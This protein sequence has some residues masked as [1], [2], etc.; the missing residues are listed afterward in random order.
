MQ[1]DSNVGHAQ[2]MQAAIEQAKRA[3]RGGDL[4]FGAVVVDARGA[5]VASAEDRIERDRDFTSHAE[6]LAVRAAAAAAGP[7]LSGCT[8]YSNGEPCALCF[9]AAWWT[10]MST[11]V[12][13]V[14]MTEL[15]AVRG[16]SMEEVMGPAHTMNQLLERKIE[17]VSDVLHDECLA[18]WTDAP[19]G[20]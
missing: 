8:L 15:K 11:L 5:I 14:S 18:L 6:C 10:R 16:D 2:Y 17:V 1:K 13:G 12:Y 9:S 20:H 7:D 4:A 3:L 19:V